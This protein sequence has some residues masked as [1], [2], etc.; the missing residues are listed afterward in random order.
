[1][2]AQR[3]YKTSNCYQTVEKESARLDKVSDLQKVL[4]DFTVILYENL[5][6]WSKL[7]VTFFFFSFFTY[8]DAMANT[9]STE[10]NQSQLRPRIQIFI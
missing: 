6:F 10:K 8:V 7:T 5:N 9:F 2:G 3:D 4:K 1:V